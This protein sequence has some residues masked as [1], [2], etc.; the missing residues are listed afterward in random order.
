MFFARSRVTEYFL[1]KDIPVRIIPI[2]GRIM[3][4]SSNIFIPMKKRRRTCFRNGTILPFAIWTLE[5]GAG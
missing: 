2:V 5:S 4:V 1:K 3:K